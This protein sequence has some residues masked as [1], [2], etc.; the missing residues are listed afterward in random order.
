MS[1]P[2]FDPFRA[3]S[4]MLWR[5]RA[6]RWRAN[7]AETVFHALALLALAVL[8]LWPLPDLLARTDS[9]T[10]VREALQQWPL[11][12]ALA[13]FVA[14]LLRQHRVVAH[15]R[16]LQTRHWLAL[17]PLQS[18]LL[19]SRRDHRQRREALL[20]VGAIAL[21]LVAADAHLHGIA[22]AALLATLA[23]LLAPH[24]PQRGDPQTAT[25]LRLHSAVCDA[26]VGRLW[27]WQ[28]IDIGIAFRGRSLAGGVLILLLVP[29]G[30]HPLTIAVTLLCG[31]AIAWLL[32][33]WRRSVAV[34]PAAQAWLGTLPLRSARLL[35]ATVG[36]P[37]LVLGVSMILLLIGFATLGAS[38]FGAIAALGVL[39]LG[40]LHF[41]C[42][43]AQRRSPRRIGIV[44]AV[45]AGV[46]V[47]VLQAMPPLA[48]LVWL[49]QLAWLWRVAVRP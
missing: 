26:G 29:M 20:Q 2:V 9:A 3:E 11:A 19:R 18:R 33:A 16:A 8:L 47:A 31:L 34:L 41:A 6:A 25:N 46:L 30:S 48:P 17:Q 13:V 12:I 35:R 27:R 39:A 23:L 49:A 45:Q 40:A 36:V 5:N 1:I 42:V 21:V 7:A 14:M 22:V 37:L 24:L 43:A 4:A 15:E 44:F 10:R 38:R 32:T 28:K